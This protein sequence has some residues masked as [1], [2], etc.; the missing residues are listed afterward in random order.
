[1][2]QLATCEKCKKTTYNGCGKHLSTIFKDKKIEDL[3]KC[4]E[5]M[6]KYIQSLSKK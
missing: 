3:C 2:C 1:M 6:R 5:I 4:T